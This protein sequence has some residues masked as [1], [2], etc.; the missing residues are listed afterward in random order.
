VIDRIYVENGV[1][2][3]VMEAIN[4][5]TPK[6]GVTAVWQHDI[7]PQMQRKQYGDEWWI[8]DIAGQ[9]MAILTQDTAILGAAEARQ[10]V[11]TGERKA[12]VDHRAHV[13]ALGN[14]KYSTWHKLRCVVQH[15]D[16]IEE[17]LGEP[18]PQAAR[19]LLSKATVETFS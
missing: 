10:G 1:G 6:H 9:G 18:G 4:L 12:I 15:W 17:M 2:R 3:S 16:L 13:I 8:E 14:A 7:H 11:I 19:L 5:F